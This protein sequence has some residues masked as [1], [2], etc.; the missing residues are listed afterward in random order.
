LLAGHR[1]EERMPDPT[2]PKQDTRFKPGQSGNPAV[3]PRVRAT[4]SARSYLRRLPLILMLT[5]KR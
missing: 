2:G 4:R 3:G 1:K 5:A